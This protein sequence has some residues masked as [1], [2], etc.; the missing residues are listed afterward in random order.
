[1]ILSTREPP[2]AWGK[3]VLG[4]RDSMRRNLGLPNA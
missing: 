2:P 1:V 4:S 3:R